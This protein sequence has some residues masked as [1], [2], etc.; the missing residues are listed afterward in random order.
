VQK[1][2]GQK[3]EVLNCGGIESKMIQTLADKSASQ[4]KTD[5]LKPFI[6]LLKKRFEY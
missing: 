2:K 4:G 1:G 3:R 6:L 5:R